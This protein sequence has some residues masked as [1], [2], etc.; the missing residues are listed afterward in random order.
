MIIAYAAVRLYFAIS[1][2]IPPYLVF[3][4]I[5]SAALANGCN[6]NQ[7]GVLTLVAVKSMGWLR[8][9]SGMCIGRPLAAIGVKR[10]Q[11]I[12]F[13]IV[14]GGLAA[15][16]LAI[17]PRW[18]AI[19]AALFLTG[20]FLERAD[21]EFARLEG[22]ANRA[23]DRYALIVY[24]L[25]N[26]L[27]FVG[28]GIGLRDGIY[29]LWEIPMGMLAAFGLAV[30]PWLVKRLEAIDGKRSAE[31]DGIAGID[32]D[33]LLFIVPLAIWAGWAEGLMLVAAFAGTT[34]VCALY[35]TH[36]RKFQ[37]KR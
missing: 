8:R 24:S 19:G 20:L 25:T 31:L 27:A 14:L 23:S 7:F 34:F 22:Q 3:R 11:V 32:G 10:E 35:L 30:L 4:H 6:S 16:A 5:K 17:G 18:F 33:D 29:G 13:R 12:T 21:H 26:A 2:C 36:F 37:S 28:L 9:L 1:A 15:L